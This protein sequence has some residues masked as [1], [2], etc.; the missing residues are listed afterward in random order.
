[1]S[2][3][4]STI[5]SGMLSQEG[6]RCFFL[7]MCTECDPERTFTDTSCTR[8]TTIRLDQMK[9]ALY[10]KA[11][12]LTSMQTIVGA[13][14]S[15]D[16]TQ[17]YMWQL[18]FRR[19]DNWLHSNTRLWFNNDMS[20]WQVAKTYSQK[21]LMQGE[22]AG[23]EKNLCCKMGASNILHQATHIRSFNSVD[24][25]LIDILLQFDTC[26]CREFEFAL[27]RKQRDGKAHKCQ[28]TIEMNESRRLYLDSSGRI[29]SI[30]HL[31]RELQH[32][33]KN[34]KWILVPSKLFSHSVS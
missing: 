2:R 23:V 33:M 15:S 34:V 28:W 4:A 30:D 20:P 26:Q 21:M 32:A 8:N 16:I 17:L 19:W 9:R 10:G 29:D 12:N 27:R 18:L 31:T 5:A 25:I 3:H 22:D 24:N 6:G 14:V 13:E 1:M 7:A 11:C